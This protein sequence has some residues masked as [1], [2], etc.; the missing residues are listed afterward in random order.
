MVAELSSVEKLRLQSVVM[1]QLEQKY[2]PFPLEETK[3]RHKQRELF[4]QKDAPRRWRG[5]Q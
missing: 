2:G 4:S 5:Q 1:Q 3:A